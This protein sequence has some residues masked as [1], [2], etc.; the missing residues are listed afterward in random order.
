MKKIV[1]FI[2]AFL[3]LGITTGL[4]VNIHYCMGKITDVKFEYPQN[5]KTCSTCKTKMPCCHDHYQLVKVN[6]EHQQAA[7]DFKI[8][9]PGVQ[10]H[11]F[12]DLVVQL[13]LRMLQHSNTNII[14]PPLLLCPDI[15]IQNCVFR[16]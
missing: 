15:N 7:T 1:A 8:E 9:I 11:T 3:Y 12:N 16:I 6:D 10:L 13:S 5:Q 4:A 2:L 14:P